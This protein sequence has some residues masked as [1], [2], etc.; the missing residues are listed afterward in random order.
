VLTEDDLE[1]LLQELKKLNLL[2]PLLVFEMSSVPEIRELAT[3]AL[4]NLTTV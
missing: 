3:E 4:T 2:E 1:D